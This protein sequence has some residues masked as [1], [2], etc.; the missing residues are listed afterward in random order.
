VLTGGARAA[1]DIDV[2]LAEETDCGDRHEDPLT[3]LRAA[4]EKRWS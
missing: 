2:L 1:A 3:M 4:A